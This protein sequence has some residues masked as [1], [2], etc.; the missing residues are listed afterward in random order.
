MAP[1]IIAR[2]GAREGAD[3]TSGLQM[4]DF[5][6]VG[7]VI[8]ALAAAGDMESESSI[9]NVCS[10]EPVT[11]RRA[12][13]AL[14]DAMDAPRD[15]LRFGALPDRA[16]ETPWMVG[17]GRRFRAASGWAPRTSLEDG[18]RLTVEAA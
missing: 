12:A 6:Y 17:D 1:H 15:L 11:V 10:G 3:L 9:Y 5:V 4:R 14:A 2:L 7:D 13:E 8:D 16:D 18:A